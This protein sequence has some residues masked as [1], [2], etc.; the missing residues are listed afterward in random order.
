MKT[1]KKPARKSLPKTVLPRIY[2]IEDDWKW[3]IAEMKKLV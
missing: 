3:H 2:R 1:E